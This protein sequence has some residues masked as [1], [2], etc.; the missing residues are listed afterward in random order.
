VPISAKAM[1]VPTTPSTAT[2]TTGPSSQLASP[3]CQS[4]YGAVQIVASAST[5]AIRFTDP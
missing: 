2:A 4:P 1:P 3:I 5:L